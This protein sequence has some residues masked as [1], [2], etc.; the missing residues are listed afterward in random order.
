MLTQKQTFRPLGES[1]EAGI[2]YNNYKAFWHFHQ[3]EE[4]AEVNSS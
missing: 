3:N 4:D 1:G 2:P